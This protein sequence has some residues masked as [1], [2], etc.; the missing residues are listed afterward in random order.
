[1]GIG[2]IIDPS[3]VRKYYDVYTSYKK[4]KRSSYSTSMSVIAS[5]RLGIGATIDPNKVS[6][7]QLVHEGWALDIVLMLAICLE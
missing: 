5:T 7:D 4:Q 6:H 2:V 3:E 1:L